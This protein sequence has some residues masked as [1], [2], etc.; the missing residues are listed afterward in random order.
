MDD[1]LLLA[2]DGSER[3]RKAAEH[4][5]GIASCCNGTLSVLYVIDTRTAY[6]NAIVSPD[7]MRENLH[8]EGEEVIASVMELAAES[9]V[10]CD[11]AI[12]EGVPAEQIE[13]FVTAHDIDQVFLGQYGHSPFETVLLGSTAEAVLHRIDQPVTVV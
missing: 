3:A 4:A 2:T 9:G 13:A 1:R 12:E 10:Q 6:D 5:I 11:S 7:E 8:E